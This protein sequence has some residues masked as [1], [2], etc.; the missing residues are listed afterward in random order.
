LGIPR[1]IDEKPPHVNGTE[2][3]IAYLFWLT[4]IP[5][6]LPCPKKNAHG[7]TLAALLC[8]RYFFFPHF[9]QSYFSIKA[10]LDIQNSVLCRLNIDLLIVL[11]GLKVHISHQVKKFSQNSPNAPNRR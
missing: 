4:Q 11:A 9:L 1:N 5:M 7:G 10:R 8:S 3:G 6:D 2:G